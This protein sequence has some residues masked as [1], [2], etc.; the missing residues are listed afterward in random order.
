MYISRIRIE[1]FR[2]FHNFDVQLG[3][4]AV[5]VGENKIG[6]SNLLHALRLLLDPSL[7]DSARQ[8]RDED[9]WDGLPR[10]LGKR[11]VITISIDLA[12]FEKDDRLLAVL[13][14][15][16]ISTDP[17][18]SRLTYVFGP[19]R[20]AGEDITEADY[21]FLI[22][23]G[24]RP[25]NKVGFELRRRLPLDL[26][27]ALRDA[28]GDLANWRKSPLR[29]LLDEASAHIDRN[30]LKTIADEISEVTDTVS[31]INEI[32]ELAE[33]ITGR[34]TQM[35]GTAHALEMTLGFSPTSPDRL[36]RALRLFIDDGRRGI[37]EAS[38]GSANLLYL[39]LTMLELEHLVEQRTRDHTFLAIEEPEAHLHPHVQRL[40]YRDLLQ[41]RVHQD[42][43]TGD[44]KH[45]V[46]NSTIFLT[47]HSPHIVSVS[48]VRSLVLLRKARNEQSTIG[49][50]AARIDLEE[51]D[52]EDL[53]RY[54]DVTRGE[55]L[56]AKG[57][58]LVEGDAELF[59]VP[60]LA[61]LNGFDL[62]QL[63]ITVSSVSGTNFAPYIKLL[64]PEGLNVPFAILTDRDPQVGGKNLGNSRAAQLLE[65][66]S[67]KLKY[68]EADIID[69]A[70]K[71]GIFL[72]DFTFEVDLFK[73]GRHKSMCKTLLD[74]STN[75]ACHERAKKWMAD[76]SSLDSV[77]LLSDIS[78]IGKG[79]FAQRLASNISGTACPIY[80][81]QAVEYV[82]KRCS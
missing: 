40:V 28:E 27:H 17:M 46:S 9:F 42:V 43:K 44:E 4:N 2:N 26:L 76:P 21:D 47:T 38:V 77:Q 32:D 48:P 3:E 82:I 72:N 69:V 56:F 62:D 58:L 61:K 30:T 39:T 33:S 79:R 23:G 35:V 59:L 10:P 53:E 29:P 64:G 75:G 12:D 49:S 66:L 19:L 67:P 57:V 37:G 54:L 1:N 15:Y 65:V 70:A 34:L 20:A 36:I 78:D 31:D 25:D 22:Y 63:G 80:I 60:A 50:S 16:P 68:A 81:K 13:G 45:G 41:S 74:L 55:M 71:R 5:I 6:K 14:E 11:D 18:V 73:C 52:I 8:L 7:P 24:D 51:S